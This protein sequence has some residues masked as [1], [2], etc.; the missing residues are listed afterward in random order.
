MRRLSDQ[1]G[2]GW[3]IFMTGLIED[4]ETPDA[5][6]P[7]AGEPDSGWR[8]WLMLLALVADV[9]G[10]FGAILHGFFG[11]FAALLLVASGV[12]VVRIRAYAKASGA[13]PAKVASDGILVIAVVLLATTGGYF[14][15]APDD[16]LRTGQTG[17][18]DQLE[19]TSGSTAGVLSN[20]SR[21]ITRNGLTL[22]VNRVGN[23]DC[24]VAGRLCGYVEFTLTNAGAEKFLFCGI[25]CGGSRAILTDGQG[26]RHSDVQEADSDS[27]NGRADTLNVNPGRSLLVTYCYKTEF[28]PGKQP[29]DF[30]L[31]TDSDTYS[32]EGIGAAGP[33]PTHR[34]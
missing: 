22:T 4:V 32:V 27:C 24:Q 29:I 17:A 1:R 15:G 13:S 14:L 34:P 33:G 31:Q 11:L 20:G 10:A 18:S 3:G 28:L 30:A 19:G 9:L 6:R 23:Q 8:L 21:A 25:G 5:R 7:D 16:S 26:Q 12:L 2:L